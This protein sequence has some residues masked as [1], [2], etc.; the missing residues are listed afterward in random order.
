MQVCV[1]G[2]W[3]LG[4]VTAAAVA[5]HHEVAAL[6][7][8]AANIAALKQGQP[9][10]FEPGLSE[11]IQA[12]ISRGSLRFTA[13]P[14]EALKSAEI[15]W[16]TFDT[17]VN[18]LD[19]ADS[20]SV[21]RQIRRLFPYLRDDAHVLIS[22]QLPVGTTARL[23]AEYRRA[24]PGG[25]AQFAYSPEN[26]RL[27]KALAVFRNP[28]RIILGVRRA[29]RSG[30]L[31]AFLSGF[32]ANVI[33]MSVE[34]AE[35]TKHALNAFLAN[36]IAFMNEIAVIS[37]HVG[38]DAKEIERGLKTE[39]R[40][41]PLAYLSPGGAFAGGT[42]ARDVA[43]LSR[44]SEQVRAPGILLKYIRESNELHKKWPQRKLEA[45]LGSVQDKVVALLGLTYKPGTDTLRRSAAVEI[46]GWV[47]RNGGTVRAF[48]PAVKGLPDELSTQIRLCESA[49]EA[50]RGADA[51]VL[52]TEWPVFRELQRGDFL[53]RMR[54]PVVIDASRFLHKHLDVSDPIIYAAVG[55]PGRIG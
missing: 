16:I 15:V 27:G 33:C 40:I 3:H 11:L 22:S 52:A 51:A 54:K 26:L 50:L 28:G 9:P 35:M 34:S 39:E 30:R 2:L 55:Q 41:G 6:D 23:E 14:G 38:A 24:A 4:C 10:I 43:F 25:S 48:D 32:C 47:H 17:P 45:L 31:I 12:G 7:F 1:F 37:E 13:D 46:A 20:E 19:E 49:G 18:E 53:D 29:D 5:E 8:D 44:F 21:E 42:L 36:S